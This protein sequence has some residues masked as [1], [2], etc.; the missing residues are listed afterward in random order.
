[1]LDFH[2]SHE[3]TQAEAYCVQITVPSTGTKRE[4]K[5]SLAFVIMA[6]IFYPNI[7]QKP[8]EFWIFFL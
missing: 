5:D 7:K 2:E 3:L 8:Y 1:M 6:S 4:E